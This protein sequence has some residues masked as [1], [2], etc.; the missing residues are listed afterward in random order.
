MKQLFTILAA[1]LI[2][3]V[4]M[5]QTENLKDNNFQNSADNL[6]RSQKGLT[7]GGY[8]QIDYN[9]PYGNDFRSNGKLD[10]HRLVM[11]LGYNFND[12]LKFV[13]E[14]EFEHVKEVYVEQAFLQYKIN[15]F[16]NFR[17][18]LMLVPMGIQNEYHEPNTFNGVERTLLDSKIAPT[19]WR[20]IG[21][22][23]TGNI[24]DASLKY[25][26]YVFNGFNGYQDG[27]GKFKGE[28]GLRKGRQKGAESF[29][30]S[31]NFAGKVEFYGVKGLNLGLSGYFGK[32]Q[33]TAYDG[34]LNSDN[35]ALQSADSTVVNISM[36]GFDARYQLKALQLRGQFYYTALGNT[37]QYNA[38]TG[39]DLGSAMMGYY[40]E[41]GYNVLAHCD[42]VDDEL[43]PFV[44]YEMYNTH[45]EV[46]DGMVQ[47][48]SY[49]NTVITAGLGWKITPKAALKVDV[50]LVKSEAADDYSKTFNAG[51][52]VMF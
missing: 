14:L 25:Q 31:P 19:T 7:L 12:R 22:G 1:L 49:N 24:I 43:I 9:Q 20:E 2:S 8:A 15:D 32:T 50:S 27:E 33:S 11:L 51:V 35:A 29:M 5:S 45:H 48:D 37:D 16:I 47:N 36:V 30:S 46:E 13:S 18:G 17:A 21:A 10:V 4:A 41:A 52:A 3:T 38:K 26:V 39:K 23:F 6:L 40:V 44:R 34:L 28:S 42:K